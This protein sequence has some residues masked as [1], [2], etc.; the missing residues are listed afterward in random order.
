MFEKLGHSLASFPDTD[1][2]IIGFPVATQVNST[3]NIQLHPNASR[4]F[5]RLSLV[6]LAAYWTILK[7]LFTLKP[8]ILIVTTHELLW[9][10][11]ICKLLFQCRVTYDVQENY[12]YNIL[13]TRSFPFVLRHVL[14]LYVRI[15]EIV[16]S[17]FIYYYTLAEKGYEHELRF[18]RPCIIL[19]NKLPERLAKLYSCK[20]SVKK[21]GLI[22]SGTLA[23]TTGVLE[24]I[25]LAVSLHKVAPDITLTIIGNCHSPSFLSVLRKKTA[26]HSFI[27]FKGGEFPVSHDQILAE[28]AQAHAGIII[29]PPNRSTHSSIPTKLYEYLAIGLPVIIQHNEA[30]ENLVKNLHAGTVLSK[31]YDPV[32]VLTEVTAIKP[33]AA[34]QSIYWETQEKGLFRLL[35]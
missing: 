16:A 11:V 18:A 26:G 1:V 17:P 28:L 5:G 8:A 7:K 13:S 14:A 29:Y 6:R 22:F 33:V 9:E 27:R 15:K 25:D 19:E 32:W 10:A 12:F 20:P 35:E 3:S 2:H 24:A 31:E 23:E 34:S 30:S 21:T 4:P